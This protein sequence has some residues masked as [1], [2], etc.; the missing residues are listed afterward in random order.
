M[1]KSSGPRIEPCGTPVVIMA[2]S[3]LVLLNKHIAFVQ[4]D[5]F[6]LGQ[7]SFQTGHKTGVYV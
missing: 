1:L 4:S 7:G 6:S 2:R 5:S 3:D